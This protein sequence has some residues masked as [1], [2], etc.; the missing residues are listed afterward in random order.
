MK[1]ST[2]FKRA[3]KYVEEHPGQ[4]AWFYAQAIAV[5][6]SGLNQRD[7]E[8]FAAEYLTNIDMPKEPDDDR[9]VAFCFLAAIAA[10]E[11]R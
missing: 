2:A 8:E 1:L 4:N 10:S 7:L 5:R 3:A 11:G 9:V 6:S